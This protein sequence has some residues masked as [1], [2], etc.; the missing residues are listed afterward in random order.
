MKKY[1]F[2]LG[3]AQVLVTVV[4]GLLAHYAAGL[5][6]PAA[7]VIGNGLALSS[8]AVGL[9]NFPLWSVRDALHQYQHSDVITKPNMHKVSF[10]WPQAVA[11]DP[12]KNWEFKHLPI[13]DGFKCHGLWPH[14]SYSNPTP[15]LPQN[16]IITT[17]QYEELKFLKSEISLIYWPMFDNLTVSRK[18]PVFR[19]GNSI[20]TQEPIAYFGLPSIY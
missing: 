11:Q 9:Q 14:T 1:G 15:P 5:A 8:T 17:E 20:N 10:Q 12:T 18:P 13:Y 6:G 4:I 16:R 2:N 7:I 3:F 19:S